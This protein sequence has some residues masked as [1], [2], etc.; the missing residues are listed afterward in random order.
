MNDENSTPESTPATTPVA[1]SPATAPTAEATTGARTRS[2]TRTLLIAGGSVLAAAVLAGGGIAVGAAIADD[3]GEDD[4]RSSSS[5]S[6]DDDANASDDGS[7]DNSSD[8][9]AQGDSDQ[10]AAVGSDS[11]DELNDIIST[12]SAEADGDAVSIEANRDGSWDVTFETSAG[13]ETDVRVTGDGAAEVVSTEAARANDTGPAGALDAATVD[14]LV[15]A[16]LAEADG[17]V[18]DIEI[19]DDT[20]SPYDISVVTADGTTVELDLDADLKVLSTTG[21]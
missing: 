21:S 14:D 1:G 18:T 16:A 4:D 9:D 13:D 19:D 10:G 8:D 12:A 6:G 17:K 5:T 20:A 2:R 15:A 7:D 3:M 11:A